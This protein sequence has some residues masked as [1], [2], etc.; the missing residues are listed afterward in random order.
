MYAQMTEDLRNSLENFNNLQQ[1]DK[2]LVFK[3][4]EKMYHSPEFSDFV[5][6]A[7]WDFENDEDWLKA[8]IEHA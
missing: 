6:E 3:L 5:S 4:I 2:G 1:E 7:G 8:V